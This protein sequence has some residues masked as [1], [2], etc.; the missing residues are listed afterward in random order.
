MLFL[1]QPG[2]L[3]AFAAKEHC[4]LVQQG[5]QILFCKAALQ[6]L[7][8]QHVLMQGIIPPHA[9]AWLGISLFWSWWD[10]CWPIS[11]DYCGPSAGQQTPLVHLP[12]LS[13]LHPLQ[14]CWGCN[15]SCY[16][17]SLTDLLNHTWPSINPRDPPLV[18]GL[19][20]DF[21]QLITTLW[22]QQFS[23]IS[24]HFTVHLLPLH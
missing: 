7:S 14:I 24:S 22:A 3:W 20:L 13:V 4:I 12:L 19:Q 5:P 15:L 2:R 9:G 10:S 6:Q 8:S 1:M 21:L 17:W 16:S 18:T 23:Q 11:P